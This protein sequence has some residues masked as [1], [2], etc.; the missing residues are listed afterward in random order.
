MEALPRILADER[1]VVNALRPV[2]STARVHSSTKGL[3]KLLTAR[4]NR[5]NEY[6]RP[7]M[8]ALPRQEG[9]LAATNQ[10]VTLVLQHPRTGM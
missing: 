5:S 6:L 8:G 10:Q 4:F 3:Y 2:I 7:S 1:L 9:G